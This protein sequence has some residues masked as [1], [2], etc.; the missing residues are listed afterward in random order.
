MV[1]VKNA[2]LREGKEGKSFVSLELTGDIELVQSQNTGRFYATSKR[3]FISSTFDLD[4]AQSFI[5]KTMPGK[6]VRSICDPYEYTVPESGETLLLGYTY[7]YQPDDMP[8]QLFIP[9]APAVGLYE[10]IED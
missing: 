7:Q 4:T 10:T 2:L 5:G 8:E 9:P 1:K 3:C 6:I